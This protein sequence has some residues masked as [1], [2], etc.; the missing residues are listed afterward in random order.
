MSL[1]VL[2]IGYD[3]LKFLSPGEDLVFYFELL[4]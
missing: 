3:G 4:A 2:L 1:C